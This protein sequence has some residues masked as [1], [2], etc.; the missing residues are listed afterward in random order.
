[1]NGTNIHKNSRRLSLG[2]AHDREFQRTEVLEESV[3]DLIRAI[4]SRAKASVD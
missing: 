4:S 1:V 3:R 2:K